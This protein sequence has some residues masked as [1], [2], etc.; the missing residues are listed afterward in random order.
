M[1]LLSSLHVVGLLICDLELADELEYGLQDTVDWRK[2]C[3]LDYND[4]E[5][6]LDS[7]NSTQLGVLIFCLFLKLPLKKLAVIFSMNFFSEVTISL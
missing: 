5:T 7:F 6:Q 3:L 2:K 1:I 4:W